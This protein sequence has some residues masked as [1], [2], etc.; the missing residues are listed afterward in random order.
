ME[1]ID[2]QLWNANALVFKKS[3]SKILF[4]KQ[5]KI[6]QKISKNPKQKTETRIS[7]SKKKN[8]EIYRFNRND[9]YNGDISLGVSPIA[10]GG[11]LNFSVY[12]SPKGLAQKEREFVSEART[13]R[14]T[15]NE[16]DE[17]AR[18]PEYGNSCFIRRLTVLKVPTVST[19]KYKISIGLLLTGVAHIRS[20]SGHIFHSSAT[21]AISVPQ[22]NTKTLVFAANL[23]IVLSNPLPPRRLKILELITTAHNY[24]CSKRNA[25]WIVID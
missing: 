17:R 16:G 23:K 5:R 8:R 1:R 21:D 2:L 15:K 24:P 12:V 22:N 11:Q 14:Q 3:W 6:I 13:A 20:I 25:I 18:R 9:K 19:S 7:V 10:T 4:K